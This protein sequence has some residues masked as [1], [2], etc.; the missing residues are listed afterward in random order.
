MARARRHPPM[1]QRSRRIVLRL[2]EAASACGGDA[3]PQWEAE[4]RSMASAQRRKAR[5]GSA[6]H[7]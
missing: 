2:R 7:L 4:R 5:V 6:S 3:G 1:Q